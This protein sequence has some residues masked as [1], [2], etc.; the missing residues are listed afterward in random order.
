MPR[1]THCN[2]LLST[3]PGEDATAPD[4]HGDATVHDPPDDATISDSPGDTT[5]PESHGGGAT[6]GAPLGGAPGSGEQVPP[7]WAGPVP[8]SWGSS[9]QGPVQ[10]ES[11]PDRPPSGHTT[12]PP[13]EATTQLSPEPWGEPANRQPSGLPPDYTT[14]MPPSDETTTYLSPEPWAEP[15]I[16]QPPPPQKKSRMPYFLAAAGAVLLFGVALGIVF[17]PSGSETSAQPGGEVPSAQGE[18]TAP[19]T[20]QESGGDLE[21]QARAVDDLL[22]DMG[23][24]R[25]DLGGVVVGG[26]EPSG[27]QRVLEMRKGQ[28]EKARGLDVSALDNGAQMRDALVRALEASTESNQRY[29]AVA[30]GCPSEAEVADVNQRASSAKTEFLGLWAPVAAQAG[31]PARTESDI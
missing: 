3:P 20:E 1:C 10:W 4:P 17:W 24:T 15:A 31:L 12:P 29:L 25:S 6:A 18:T 16:W 27:L 23:T 7:P 9:S 30:P 19:A 21:G 8:P 26:C 5:T 13:D 22:E 11:P 2:A 14:P 28:L